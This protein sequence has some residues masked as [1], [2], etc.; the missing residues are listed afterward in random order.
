MEQIKELFDKLKQQKIDEVIELIDKYMKNEDKTIELDQGIYK[1]SKTNK[2]L[3]PQSLAQLLINSHHFTSP[4][5]HKSRAQIA[6]DINGVYH[7]DHKVLNNLIEQITGCC[8]VCQLFDSSSQKEKV[9]SL[10]RSDKPRSSWSIDLIVDMPAKDSRGLLVAVDDFSNYM[11]AVPLKDFSSMELISAVK[12]NI[13]RPFG[14]PKS[15]RSDEQPGIYNSNEFYNFLKQHSVELH[16]PA[17]ASPFSNGRVERHIKSFKHAARK[18]FYQNKCIDNW[19]DHIDTIVNSINSSIN[20][21]GYSPEE[22]MFGHKSPNKLNLLEHID[23]QE[24][25]EES[26]NSKIEKIIDRA[27]K[28]RTEYNRKKEAKEKSNK[29]FKNK[30]AI[31]KNFEL[32]DIVLHRQLQVS[33]GSSTKWKPLFTGPFVIE[34]IDK[35]SKTFTCKNLLN[36]RIS[37]AHS[38]NLTHYK[39]DRS[40]VKLSTEMLSKPIYNDS[41]KTI[42]KPQTK[43]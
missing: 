23:K 41:D 19:E 40:T 37:K 5:L 13:F 28:I 25:S 20:S 38:T 27:N 43:K 2:P 12:N 14:C 6:R 16:A 32:G 8:H 9:D 22:V 35:N 15:I 21:Y 4:G 30:T 36:D 1:S 42:K 29:T 10:R 34:E 24:D 18:Y 3:L 31:H 7:I 33:T 17:V 11:V 26:E 39:I